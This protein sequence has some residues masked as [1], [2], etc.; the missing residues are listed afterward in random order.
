M[1]VGR[2][3]AVKP[4]VLDSTDISDSALAKFHSSSIQNIHICGRRGPEH[5]TFTFP[6]LREI[7]KLDETNLLIN[8][9]TIQGCKERIIK[10]DDVTKDLRSRIETM[11]E[12][13]KVAIKEDF[14]TIHLHFFLSP[15]EILGENRVEGIVFAINELINGRIVPTEKKVS[16]KCGLVISAI[17]YESKEI[18]GLKYENGRVLNIDGRVI[19][20]NTYVV[21]WAKRG[22]SGVIGANKSDSVSVAKLIVEDLKIPKQRLSLNDLLANKG[23][24]Y[25][26]QEQWELLNQSEIYA[27]KSQGRPRI[28]FINKKDMLDLLF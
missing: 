12:V 20:R 26:S 13:S 22:A 15:I 6:E 10:F 28:K 11:L 21:G 27:G 4:S 25:I 2:M 1:D 8:Q 14:R 17:G 9:E 23:V 7:L 16:M 18:N 24:S 5:A 3:L 19:G